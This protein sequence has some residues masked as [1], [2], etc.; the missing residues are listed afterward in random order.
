[1]SYTSCDPAFNVDKNGNC[2]AGHCDQLNSPCHCE[3]EEINMV[4]LNQCKH[5]DARENPILEEKYPCQCPTVDMPQSVVRC[6]EGT[7]CQKGD[8]SKGTKGECMSVAGRL[9]GGG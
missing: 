7:A 5:Q 6:Q 1:M 3:H 9:G 2:I 4:V 8:H